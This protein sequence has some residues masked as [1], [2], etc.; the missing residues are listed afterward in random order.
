M[1]VRSAVF[2]LLTA[3]LSLS[4][5]GLPVKVDFARGKWN[6]EDFQLVKSWRFD[7][8]GDFIQK[9]DCIANRCPE[10]FTPE[11]IY[12][13]KKD[14]VYSA[15]V[16]R[17]KFSLGVTVSSRMGWDW[18]MAPIIVIAPEVPRNEKGQLQFG[19][20]WEVCLYN[21]GINLWYH[22]FK[23]GKQKWHKAASI[24]L[25]E[26]DYYAANVP[27]DLKVK[28]AKNR[29]GHKEIIMTCGDF[30]LTHVDDTLPDAF[31]A[32]IIGC[33]GRNFFWDFRVEA[34]K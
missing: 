19:D 33:E 13:K 4:A 18:L 7:Y 17:E 25:P 27:H 30:Q 16:Y 9:D 5:L 1:K 28:L 6:R 2:L 29:N 12:S 14:G 11:E 10:G 21:G 31:Y 15:M 22:F 20:H 3:A 34:V 23:D 32:G 26:R 8:L 24:L